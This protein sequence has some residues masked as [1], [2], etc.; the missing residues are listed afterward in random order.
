MEP[1]YISPAQGGTLI[2]RVQEWTNT[3]N[4]IVFLIR[5]PCG[6]RKAKIRGSEFSKK[7][8]NDVRT[9]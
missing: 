7:F 8:Q 9:F 5:D 2:G 3:R 6:S 1:S 4:I